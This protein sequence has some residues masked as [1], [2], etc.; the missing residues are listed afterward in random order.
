M[1]TPEYGY[2]EGAAVQLAYEFTCDECDE[3]VIADRCLE[4]SKLAERKAT[5]GSVC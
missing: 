2:K 1:K 5:G 4:P 3:F